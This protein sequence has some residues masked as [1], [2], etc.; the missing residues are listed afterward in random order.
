MAAGAVLVHVVPENESRSIVA[1][2][3]SRE[4]AFV[5]E[6]GLAR[7]EVEALPVSEFGRASAR[8]AR[9]S[10]DVAAQKELVDVFGESVNGAFVRVELE[11][12]DDEATRRMSPHLRSGER[13]V[14]RLH[15]RHRRI[16]GLAFDFVR[17]WVGA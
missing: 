14:V 8:V 11:L 4:V 6:G 10:A 17:K 13:L 3:P 7:V 1:F 9:I 15:R 5:S 12:V 2:L 16:I